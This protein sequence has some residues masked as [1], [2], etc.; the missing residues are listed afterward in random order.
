M[1][2]KSGTLLV[3]FI[4]L[5]PYLWAN[6]RAKDETRLR[7]CGTV[8]QEILDAPENIPQR[9]L[10]QA[11]CVVVFPA[12]RKAALGLGASYGRGAMSCRQNVGFD[13][14][15]GAPTMMVLE[16]LS[17]GFQLGAESSDFV[18]LVMNDNGGKALLTHKIKLGADVVATAG[19]VVHEDSAET[20]TTVQAEILSYARSR[21]LFAGVSLTGSTVHSDKDAN[22]QIYGQKIPAKE[23]SGKTSIP[24]AADQ[25]ISILNAKTPEHKL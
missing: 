4:V 8:L 2:N 5:A 7:E 11:D 19:P 12:V 25:L 13:G 6:N 15:W 10:D 3:A 21:G 20:D 17:V 22:L 9:L 1:P 24:P 14:P 18:L 16:G 23:I